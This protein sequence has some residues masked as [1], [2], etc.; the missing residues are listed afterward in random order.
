MMKLYLSKD[1]V[2]RVP[3]A[4][5]KSHYGMAKTI[6]GGEWRGNTEDAYA[7]MW[8]AGWVRVVETATKVNGE[9]YLN[10]KPVPFKKLTP[11]QKKWFEAQCHPG[12]RLLIWNDQKFANTRSH[13]LSMKP[14]RLTDAQKKAS[15]A[16]NRDIDNT[17]PELMDALYAANSTKPTKQAEAAHCKSLIEHAKK[18]GVTLRLHE[19]GGI[20]LA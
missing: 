10:G 18:G 5:E 16:F 13:E 15:D 8:Q 9:Q 14:K 2:V 4:E 6:L 11:K 20:C 19:D 17:S 12:G 3:T 1:G 7:S